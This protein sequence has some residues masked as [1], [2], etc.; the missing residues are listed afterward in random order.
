MK[1]LTNRQSHCLI[2]LIS[3]IALTIGLNNSAHSK[4]HTV[5]ETNNLYSQLITENKSTSNISELEKAANNLENNGNLMDALKANE[6][7]L[8]IKIEHLGKEDYWVGIVLKKIG[9]IH[10]K[11]GNMKEAEDSLKEA[12]RIFIKSKIEDSWE[13]EQ[14]LLA[15]GNIYKKQAK[16]PEA[17]AQY[18]KAKKIVE[19]FSKPNPVSSHGIY[20]S[21]GQLYHEQGKYS[22]AKE[23]YTRAVNIIEKLTGENSLIT[24]MTLQSL[25][26]LNKDL[27]LYQQAKEIYIKVLSIFENNFGT[28]HIH[29]ATV[30][31]NLSDIFLRLNAFSEAKD[32]AIKELLIKEKVLGKD[33][34][35]LV[36]PLNRLANTLASQGNGFQGG[37]YDEPFDLY[38]RALEIIKLNFGLEHHYAS[39]TMNNLAN[40][41]LT[42]DPTKALPV[43]EKTV[44]INKNIYGLSH[45][46][47]ATSLNNLAGAYAGIGDKK[48]AESY[49]IK[50][51]KIKE[52]VLPKD[53]I[54]I[55][56]TLNNLA[57]IY[58]DQGLYEQAVFYSQRALKII[59]ESV[60]EYNQITHEALTTLAASSF[61][62]G[63]YSIT[64]DA[65][66]RV[67][68][69]QTILIQR[70]APFLSI[71]KRTE[72]KKTFGRISELSYSLAQ[73]NSEYNTIALFSR[74]N[75]HGILADLEGNQSKLTNL[76]N[77][78]YEIVKELQS[79]ISSLSSFSI[80][81]SERKKLNTYRE[82][83]EQSLYKIL[84]RLKPR[85]T[86]IEEVAKAMPQK[87][88]LIEF[89]K[90]HPRVGKR[91]D[92]ARYLASILTDNHSISTIDLGPAKDIDAA[93]HKMTEGI[94]KKWND[95]TQLINNVYQLVIR[96]LK[97]ATNDASNWFISADGELN[98]M[99]F[100]SLKIPERNNSYLSDSVNL[101]L[102]TTGRELIDLTKGPK[103]SRS[104]NLI[105]A[106]PAYDAINQVS[107]RVTSVENKSNKKVY[108]SAANQ[109][110]SIWQRL[111][112][113]ALEGN[114][115]QSLIGGKLLMREQATSNNVKQI[116]APKV[117]HLATHAFYLSKG[118][119]KSDIAGEKA[120]L[121]PDKDSINNGDFYNLNPLIRSGIVL[122]GANNDDT[123]RDNDGYLTA[124]E[125]TQIDWD[126]TELVVVSGC[127]SGRGEI[128][129]GEGIY[130][131]KRAI[132]VAGARSSLLS[133]WKVDDE[134]TAAFMTSFYTRLKDGSGRGDALSATQKEFR[135]HP[136][137]DWREPYVWAAFQLSGDWGPIEGL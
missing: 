81:P 8:K 104:Q 113:T 103:S 64:E 41:L 90:Y 106:D 37:G 46:Y 49:Y 4:D 61:N 11:L 121:D 9:S 60:G 48:K 98:R 123:S 5:L 65:I 25:A 95:S 78:Q 131:L 76:S 89:Q 129:A 135:T 74:I 24:A 110:Q 14:T 124:L 109:N 116:S 27:G 137:E 132:A 22:K 43:L 79:V 44:Q 97:K 55:G 51:L 33:H 28:Y 19:N 75:L 119:S 58:S 99:P 73:R 136:N 108:R 69:I 42:T 70:E 18:I 7:I 38:L 68:Q 118:S 53:H 85:I 127:E 3:A 57:N 100:N 66:K 31:G 40:M 126:G 29:T 21:F 67:I 82:T 134:A 30:I 59:R 35:D 36:M 10:T 84:P 87:S 45:P 39:L 111:K 54:D 34:P 102:I 117:V 83:L 94:E 133:L 93:I 52:E 120:V 96:P 2:K 26:E 80:E 62:A 88:V 15:L 112:E 47:T 20:F 17:E 105:V 122:S 114:S 63:K 101:R 50:S 91:W 71:S 128:R 56:I 23:Y 1:L 12:L 107:D 115:I 77:T 32:Y 130:G 16:F 86:S 6:Q 72:F 13:I 125:I 92:R